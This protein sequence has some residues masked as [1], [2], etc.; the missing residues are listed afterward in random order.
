MKIIKHVGLYSNIYNGFLVFKLHKHNKYYRLHNSNILCVILQPGS[1][2]FNLTIRL[3]YSIY[4][5]CG[6]PID[7]TSGVIWSFLWR[8]IES[9]PPLIR[10]PQ[11]K[12]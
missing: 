9:F 8:G 6:L 3:E 12:N 1:R 4:Y 11:K 7:N 2:T 5:L 10:H